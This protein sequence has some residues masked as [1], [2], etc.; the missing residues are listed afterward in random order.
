M[1]SDTDQ[2]PPLPTMSSQA[3]S[4]VKTEV[5]SWN[6]RDVYLT[7]LTITIAEQLGPLGEIGH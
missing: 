6:S 7:P 2:C 1:S 4:Q 5:N 3:G